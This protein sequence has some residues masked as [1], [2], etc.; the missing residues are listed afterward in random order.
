[1]KIN[2]IQAQLAF[3]RQLISNLHMNVEV[4][5]ASREQASKDGRTVYSDFSHRNVVKN[6]KRIAKLVTLQKALKKDLA[7]ELAYERAA[8]QMALIKASVMSNVGEGF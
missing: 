8:R 4:D 1:M 7:R 6:T 2:Q 3:N 5:K